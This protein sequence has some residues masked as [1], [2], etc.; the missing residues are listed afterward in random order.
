MPRWRSASGSVRN[1]PNRWVQNAPRVVHVFW[2]VRRQPPAASSRSARLLMPAR[3]LPAS[4]SLQPWHQRSSAAAMRGRMRSCCSW[5]PNSKTV[6]RQQEDAVLGDPLGAAD[7]VV[8]LLEDQPLPQRWRR[9]RR[10]PRATTPPTSGP[11]NSCRS[12]SRWRAKPSR[13][14]ARRQRLG[15]H[16]GL[17][18]GAGLGPERL[19]GVGEGQVH[20]GAQP[21]A[22]SDPPQGDRWRRALRWGVLVGC[23]TCL[24]QVRLTVDHRRL[25]R[26]ERPAA[27]TRRRLDGDAVRDE[28]LA[29]NEQLRNRLA[30]RRPRP[31]Q[32]PAPVPPRA[33]AHAVPGRAAQAAAPPRGAR[34]AH[35]RAVRGPRRGRQG[36]HHPPGHPLH[37]RE[38][39]PGGRPGPA[40][41]GAAHAVVLPALRRAVPH[42]RRD[43]PVR[44]QLVQ[45]GH[46]RAG[47]RLLH[48]RRVPQ[49]HEGRGRLREGPRPP[50]H[51][52]GEA[53][54]LGVEGGAAAPVRPPPHRPAAPVEAERGRPAGPGALGRLHRR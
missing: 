25:D 2:P 21:D 52:A 39:L 47:V 37:E 43:R 48:R 11:S 53:L 18:P 17:E 51:D 40:H 9:A 41:R 50:G 24:D 38:A 8:L 42:R 19:L 31:A 29:E 5:V 6:G 35:D 46:G 33:R 7:P 27:A 14:V 26:P 30:D 20:R 10:R 13:G 44:P 54:L 12:Q 45:P 23:S 3:S 32:G 22:P 1:R 49:L 15:R 16:V 4:G 34:P 36:R 28:L